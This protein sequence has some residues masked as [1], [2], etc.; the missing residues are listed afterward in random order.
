M[1]KVTIYD[2]NGESKSKLFPTYE[3]AEAWVRYWKA[4]LDIEFW[5]YDIEK[6]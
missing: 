3:L 4:L 6:N 1:Y 2:I 5:K